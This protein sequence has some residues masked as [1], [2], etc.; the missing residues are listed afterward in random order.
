MTSPNRAVVV[1]TGLIG[2]SIGMALRAR[3][4][5]VTGRDRDQGR[6]E[7]ALSLGALDAIGSDPAAELTFVAT[8]VSAVV[9]E[10]AEALSGGGVVTDV[11]SV[12]VPIVTA[13]D[14][15]RFVGGHPMAGSE[16]EGVQGAD[17][18]LFEGATW[19]LTP[20][21][22]TDPE[23]YARV[24]AVVS[25]LGADVLAVPPQRHDELVA[26]VSHVPHL[27]AAALMTLAADGAE[28][29]RTLLRLAA[30]GFRDMTRIAAGHPGIW[31]DICA[32]NRQAIL[33]VLDRLIDTLGDLRTIVDEAD[34]PS[35]LRTLERARHARVNLPTRLMR[36][37]SLVEVRVPI[38]DRPG[39]LAE[40][41]TVAAD[42]GVNVED[43]EI[44]HSPEGER[45]VLLLL[46]DAGAGELLREALYARG[47]RP[48]M[49][50]LAL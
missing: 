10:A 5:F 35:L 33:G 36:A 4:W 28:E 49:Q 24:R 15:P 11:G 39:V 31:P 12:K 9:A 20:T 32:D 44:A 16:Q 6:A 3:G 8:P 30:G 13:V 17:P 27:T 21:A 41:T 14:H 25:S 37:E 26:V 45:G 50:P 48:S 46:I 43:L 7:M 38:P 1:G 40:V 23:A 47:Y 34:R 18:A 42:L 29:H 22:S 19:V 2:G